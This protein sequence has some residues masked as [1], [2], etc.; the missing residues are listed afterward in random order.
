MK[1]MVSLF[2]FFFAS[3][4]NAGLL[5]NISEDTNSNVVFTFSGSVVVNQGEIPYG[6]IGF[7]FGDITDQIYS[8]ATGLYGGAGSNSF[9]VENTTQGTNSTLQ[10]IYLNSGAG[11]QLGIRINNFFVLTAADDGDRIAWS[12]LVTLYDNDFSN[13]TSGTWTGNRLNAGF[14]DELILLG[15]GYTITID[16][17]IAHISEPA[18]LILLGLGIAGIGFTR[19]KKSA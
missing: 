2:L 15:D 11:Q 6:A 13:F 8:G 12:G 3:I 1:I 17:Q 18:S 19:K 9:F 10:G 5:L 16:D 4:T 7:W 14:D